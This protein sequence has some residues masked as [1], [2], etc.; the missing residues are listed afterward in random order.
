VA[1][2]TMRRKEKRRVP[3]CKEGDTRHT[4]YQASAINLQFD[5]QGPTATMKTLKAKPCHLTTPIYRSQLPLTKTTT[6]RFRL[7]FH[8]TD[9]QRVRGLTMGRGKRKNMFHQDS[10][11]KAFFGSNRIHKNCTKIQRTVIGT[12]HILQAKFQRPAEE[13]EGLGVKNHCKEKR[14]GGRPHRDQPTAGQGRP[15]SEAFQLS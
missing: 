3:D 10:P 15:F 14:L 6:V 1:V 12:T 13:I 8:T 7:P 2:A 4:G 9:H 5:N 11:R